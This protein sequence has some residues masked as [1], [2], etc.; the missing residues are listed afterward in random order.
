MIF[1]GIDPGLSGALAFYDSVDKTL[2]VHDMPTVSV[3][4]GGK[5]KNEVSPQLASNIIAGGRPQ[6][7]YLERVG[8]MPGQGVTSVFSFGRSSGII[9]GILA[10]YDI[11]TTI[12]PPQAWMKATGIRAG[13]DG[14]RQRAMEIFP[15]Y[16]DLFARK[17]DDGRSDAAL[18]AYYGASQ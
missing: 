5:N 7:A 18:I 14:S 15:Q 16:A 17:K 8:A 11:A 2:T 13:K 1:L 12:I 6:Y 3:M 9:E 4:R 10:A